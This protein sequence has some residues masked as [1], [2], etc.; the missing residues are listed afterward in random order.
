MIIKTGIY[1]KMSISRTD[2]LDIGPSMPDK[3]LLISQEVSEIKNSIQQED[4]AIE[5]IIKKFTKSLGGVLWYNSSQPYFKEIDLINFK[6]KIKTDYNVSFEYCIYKVNR[7]IKSLQQEGVLKKDFVFK[8]EYLTIEKINDGA[9]NL[10]IQIPLSALNHD[11]ESK[12]L[13]IEELKEDKSFFP[14]SP[15]LINVNSPEKRELLLWANPLY[16]NKTLQKGS[17]GTCWY[18]VY[19]YARERRKESK[20]AIDAGKRDLEKLWSDFRSDH[21]K[22]H[23]HE[24]FLSDV[25]KELKGVTIPIEKF[26][27]SAIFE[28]YNNHHSGLPYTEDYLRYYK[29]FVDYLT[30]NYKQSH[31]GHEMV[32]KIFRD[33]VK[34][35]LLTFNIKF[36]TEKLHFNY[37]Q[38]ILD[39]YKEGQGLETIEE[40]T[41]SLQHYWALIDFILYEQQHKAYDI[42]VS[43]WNPEQSFNCLLDEIEKNGPHIFY[44]KS[45]ELKQSAKTFLFSYSGFNIYNVEQLKTIEKGGHCV[46]VIG[47]EITQDGKEFIYFIDPNDEYSYQKKPPVYKFS[48]D[49]FKLE[50]LSFYRKGPIP[51]EISQDNKPKKMFI[52]YFTIFGRHGLALTRDPVSPKEGK[53][54]LSK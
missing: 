40:V 44:L 53:P 52:E 31:V 32:L 14:K 18:N 45:W 35:A 4:F 24:C 36:L 25:I 19:L 30:I 48:F 51:P 2:S 47:G 43:S 11:I 23:S 1:F 6:L 34:S 15:Y 8:S 41:L 26:S 29:G 28:Y 46:V 39:F 9:N 16:G 22:L 49:K 7:L 12:E 17:R 33:Y 50:L 38:W 37:K 54:T 3:N 10:T 13:F 21:Q 27:S 5:K 42:C 20:V